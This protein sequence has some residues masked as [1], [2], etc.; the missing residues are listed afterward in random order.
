MYDGAE[1]V[2][3]PTKVCTALLTAPTWTIA[4]S[5]PPGRVLSLCVDVHSGF[6]VTACVGDAEAPPSSLQMAAL[7]ASARSLGPHPAPV[8]VSAGEHP[9]SAAVLARFCAALRVDLLGTGEAPL[10][11]LGGTVSSD[12][13]GPQARAAGATMAAV[14]ERAVAAWNNTPYELL[15]VEP[16]A[17]AMPR[18]LQQINWSAVA[19]LMAGKVGLGAGARMALG[20][21]GGTPLDPTLTPLRAAVLQLQGVGGAGAS[22]KLTARATPAT[23][24]PDSSPAEAMWA[25]S[26]L[27]QASSGGGGMAWS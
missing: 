17:T 24:K 14:L 23:R 9:F 12:A 6:V 4:S 7:G 26:L 27:P 1:D 10:A 22:Y 18:P 8:W 21:G 15:G 19:S 25:P 3:S 2:A 11:A 16:P 20:G 5:L 13:C